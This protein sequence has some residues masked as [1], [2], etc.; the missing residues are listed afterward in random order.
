MKKA[1]DLE[2][3]YPDKKFYLL[4]FDTL[5]FAQLE[6]FNFIECF[7]NTAC[8]RISYD[9]SEKFAKKVVDVNLL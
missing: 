2:R 4:L 7:V 8:P 5:D 3:K 9:D 1:H 6:N